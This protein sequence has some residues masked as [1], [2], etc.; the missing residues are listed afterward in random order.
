MVRGRHRKGENRMKNVSLRQLVEM[1]NRFR[2]RSEYRA[3]R[4]SCKATVVEW[5]WATSLMLPELPHAKA[6]FGFS[7]PRWSKKRTRYGSL[8][9]LDAAGRIRA[10]RSEDLAKPDEEVYEQFLFHDEGGFWCI[11]FGADKAKR[12]LRVRRCDTLDGRLLRDLEIGPYNVSEITADW[13]SGRLI[14]HTRRFWEGVSTEKPAAAARARFSK[15]GT[16]HTE[17]SY[18]YSPDGAL[19]RVT[20]AEYLGRE[21]EPWSQTTKYQRLPEGVTLET[22]LHDAEEALVAEVL[23]TVRA[24]KVR[25]TVYCMLLHFSGVDTDPCGFVPPL[26]LVP[27]TTRRR[28]LAE[29][30]KSEA[31]YYLWGIAE[32]VSLAEAI[33]LSCKAPALDETLNLIF[34]LTITPRGSNYEP[35]RQMFQRVCRRLNALDWKGALKTTD[36]FVIF[37]AEPHGEFNL[38]ED[39]KASVPAERIR[40]LM[41]RGYFWRVKLN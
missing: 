17:Y 18:T 30:E 8:H 11:Y 31:T 40:L 15:H 21:K 38:E 39:V 5:R 20:E 2:A 32:L 9:G 26:I 27:E 41:D 24:A 22:L 16:Q 3:L 12:L 28:I 6:L 14:R 19:E 25:E 29:K 34:Q 23:R 37:P 35:V 1:M 13:E 33:K 10:V 36:D 4:K 7:P